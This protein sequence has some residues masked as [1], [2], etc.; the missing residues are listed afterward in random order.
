[1]DNKDRN[2]KSLKDA[3]ISNIFTE[4]RKDNLDSVE[5]LYETGGYSPNDI[6][7][8]TNGQTLFQYSI[9]RK[10]RRVI[11]WFLKNKNVDLFR[12]NVYGQH[13]LHVSC[14]VNAQHAIIRITKLLS[15]THTKKE[16]KSY[17]NQFD[18]RGKTSM[19]YLA[20][21][22]NR[23]LLAFLQ[24][25]GGHVHDKDIFNIDAIGYLRA[26]FIPVSEVDKHLFM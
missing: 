3:T 12:K 21:N 13:C 24:C 14:E 20:I 6:Y 11:D 25:F 26:E 10:A 23:N 18:M 22:E 2:E 4:I 19:H 16:M 8:E 9:L 15:V 17:I 5:I 1:M 7:M